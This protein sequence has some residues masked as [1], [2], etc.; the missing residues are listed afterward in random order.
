MKMQPIVPADLFGLSDGETVSKRSLYDLIRLSKQEGTAS[1]AGPSDRIGNTPQQGI[2]WIGN[3]PGVKG[4]II[5]TR[6]GSYAHD[7]WVDEGRDTYRYSFKARK[8]VVRHDELANRVLIDQPLQL[9]P[10]LLFT[11]AGA[12]WRFEG[13]FTVTGIAEAFVM[14]HRETEASTAAVDVGD[15]V[16]RE[17]RRRYV[18]HLLAE[19]SRA[20]L[21]FIKAATAPVC[22]VCGEDTLARYGVPVIDAHHRTPLSTWTEDHEVTAADIALV[23]PSCHRAVHAHMRR[24][25]AGYEAIRLMIRAR[26]RGADVA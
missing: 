14:L 16:W 1:W 9:Y 21:A 23:C 22:D 15:M 6:P 13:R 24:E 17:G 7:G 5:K 8:G 2:N 4:V 26:L 25:N 20:L 10:V 11:E 18:T 12:H 19:R 3:P